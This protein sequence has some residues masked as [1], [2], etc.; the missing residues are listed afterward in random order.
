VTGPRDPV[1]GLTRAAQGGPLTVRGLLATIGGWL[2]VVESVLPPLLFV[3][4]YQVAAIRAAPAAVPRGSLVLIVVVPLAVSVLLVA[5]RAIRRQRMG[6][7][8]AGAVVVGVS[9]ALVLITGDANTN[10]VPGF[11]INAGYGLAFLVSLL[12]RRPLVGLAAAALT[13]RPGIDRAHRRLHGWLTGAWV[14]L[15]AIRLAVELP[16]FASHQV[17]A[18]GIARILLGVPLYAVVLVVTVLGVQAA[19]AAAEPR[20]R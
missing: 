12:V 16:L 11:F 20:E 4:L 19:T 17:V 6:A 7:A 15:F 2:G 18:L 10:Y 1:T 14:A 8:I 9:A 5:Y 3:V 13:Q